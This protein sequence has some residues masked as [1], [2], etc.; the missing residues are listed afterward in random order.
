MYRFICKQ[1]RS[2]KI[3]MYP[4]NRIGNLESRS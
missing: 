4:V 1:K 2:A 3:V